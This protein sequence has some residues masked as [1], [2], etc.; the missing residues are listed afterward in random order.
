MS[1]TFGPTMDG[2]EG[3]ARVFIVGAHLHYAAAAL[4]NL[5]Q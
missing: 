3:V 2:S 5:L 4:A 1:T